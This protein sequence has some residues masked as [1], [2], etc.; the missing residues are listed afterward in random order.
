LFEYIFL[1]FSSCFFRWFIFFFFIISWLFQSFH[2]QRFSF[3]FR[4][5]F[6]ESF[7]FSRFLLQA[8]RVFFYFLSFSLRSSFISFSMPTYYRFSF[9]DADDVWLPIELFFI[10]RFLISLLIF[11][12]RLP[13]IFL[14]R[15]LP[16]Y[17]H[18]L[19]IF[20]RLF[21]SSFF[22]WFFFHFRFITFH[23]DIFISLLRCIFI[24]YFHWYLFSFIFCLLI[25][26]ISL[27]FSS[28]SGW[29]SFFDILIWFLRWLFSLI[30]FFSS[31]FFWMVFRLTFYWFFW[32][33]SFSWFLHL[34]SIYLF[35]IF[36]WGFDFLSIDLLHWYLITFSFQ[37]SDF[38]FLM[39]R[40][41][42]WLID[43]SFIFFWYYF[44]YFHFIFYFSASDFSMPFL[45]ITLMIFFDFLLFFISS[46]DLFEILFF[47][48]F[49]RY[50]RLW[51][52]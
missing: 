50:F 46:P 29:L 52:M 25:F 36:W 11:I 19:S 31:S 6:W 49:F 22:W 51:L 45:L 13:S 20:F 33:F 4:L 10:F 12:F 9:F 43:F 48:S 3:D 30:F 15:E 34:L 16:R 44:D 14:R 38:D 21:W 35:S 26:L 37:I 2:F 17:F 32:Y 40:E 5:R 27:Y 24:I 23:F 18:F 42:F 39:I 28:S 41:L 8:F 1:I 47:I 7:L